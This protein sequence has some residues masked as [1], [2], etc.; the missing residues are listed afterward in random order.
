MFVHLRISSQLAYRDSG[1]VV[2]T[3]LIGQTLMYVKIEN[4]GV[5]LHVLKGVRSVL[6]LETNNE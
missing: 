4:A 6:W 3:R 1:G 2:K 5:T